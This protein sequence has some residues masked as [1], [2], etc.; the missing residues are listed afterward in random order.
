M[1]VS[2]LYI[3]MLNVKRSDCRPDDKLSRHLC[4]VIDLKRMILVV[5]PN[6]QSR[7][8]DIP[9]QLRVGQLKMP[10]SLQ[11]IDWPNQGLLD[12]ERARLYYTDTRLAFFIC[13]KKENFVFAPIA[14]KWLRWVS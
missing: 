13:I 2:T 8:I 4:N 12:F 11:V 10:P 9:E 3:D 7:P 5:A 1:Q 14:T 6:D